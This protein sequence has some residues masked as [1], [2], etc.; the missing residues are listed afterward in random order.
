MYI[1]NIESLYTEAEDAGNSY[2][3]EYFAGLHKVIEKR[4]EDLRKQRIAFGYE[5]AKDREGMR[6]KYL[7]MLGWPLGKEKREIRSVKQWIIY[8]DDRYEITRM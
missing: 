5:V 4:R 3:L 8:E 6:E 1:K 7:E 2:R